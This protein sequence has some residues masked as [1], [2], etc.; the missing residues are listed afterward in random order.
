MEQNLQIFPCILEK[1][2]VQNLNV[3]Y[4]APAVHSS[5]LYGGVST[6]QVSCSF[7]VAVFRIRKRIRIRRMRMVLGP[8]D[9]HPAPLV[10]STDPDPAPDPDP[11]L[12][13]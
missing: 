13:S 9:P 8:P 5:Q 12:L 6:F 3:A 4:L 7:F 1:S 10:T 11:Y 2:M